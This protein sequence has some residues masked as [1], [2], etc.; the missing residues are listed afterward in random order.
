MHNEGAMLFTTGG[1]RGRVSGVF[2]LLKLDYISKK[3]RG[4]TDL[5]RCASLILSG[6]KSTDISEMSTFEHARTTPQTIGYR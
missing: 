6:T 3:K 2:N 4:V 1:R 5:R